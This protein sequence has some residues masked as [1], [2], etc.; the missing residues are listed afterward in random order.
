MVTTLSVLVAC[1]SSETG[2]SEG[3]SGVVGGSAD[4]IFGGTIRDYRVLDASNLVVT[5]SASRR[6]HIELVRPA[7]GLKSTWQIAFLPAGSRVCRSTSQ[8][9]VNDTTGSDRVRIR[10]IWRLT[11]DEYDD[12][13]IRYGKKEPEIEQPRE[14]EEVTGAEVEELD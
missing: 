4:C 7:Y 11:P 2:P 6:Y 13:L 3:E 1:A 10:N 12:L 9:L 8:L 14:P 5:A